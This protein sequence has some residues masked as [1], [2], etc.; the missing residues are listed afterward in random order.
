MHLRTYT[1]TCMYIVTCVY[2]SATIKSESNRT[3]YTYTNMPHHTHVHTH[4]YTYGTGRWYPCHYKKSTHSSHCKHPYKLYTTYLW[5]RLEHLSTDMDLHN[6]TV[7][8][9]GFISIL[10]S[11]ILRA[12]IQCICSKS[13]SSIVRR[14]SISQEWSSALTCGCNP[15]SFPSSLGCLIAHHMGKQVSRWTLSSCKSSRKESRAYDACLLMHHRPMH[16]SMVHLAT[17]LSATCLVM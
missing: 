14:H 2:W 3:S 11:T 9:I 7:I 15:K 5:K 12:K 13:Y 16:L 17:S 6:Y 4:I 8:G 10:C 1:Y